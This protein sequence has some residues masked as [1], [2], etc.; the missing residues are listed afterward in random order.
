MSTQASSQSWTSPWW[1]RAGPDGSPGARR[2][3]DGSS[4]REQGA[5][6]Q[7]EDATAGWTRGR[8][9]DAPHDQSKDSSKKNR[10]GVASTTSRGPV[11]SPLATSSTMWTATREQ[12]KTPAQKHRDWMARM[13]RDAE[14]RRDRESDPHDVWWAQAQWKTTGPRERRRE[15]APE[16][17]RQ[18]AKWV[19]RAWGEAGD[20]SGDQ[21]R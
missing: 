5:L 17:G 9:N 18:L 13:K 21:A 20:Q 1:R 11:Q 8:R 6:L 3:G 15:R 14:R 12:E 2:F 7:R 10:S 16:Q 19:F 4:E